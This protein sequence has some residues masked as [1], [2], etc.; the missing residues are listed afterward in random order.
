MLRFTLSY[1]HYLSL[2]LLVSNQARLATHVATFFY[3]LSKFLKEQ[4]YKWLD[5]QVG[6]LPR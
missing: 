6:L 4:V 2:F 5:V 3:F 1:I